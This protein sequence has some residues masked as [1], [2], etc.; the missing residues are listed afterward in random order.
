MVRG[1][2]L[3]YRNAAHN[4]E[5]LAALNRLNSNMF[6]I[7]SIEANPEIVSSLIPGVLQRNAKSWL[8]LYE[9]D[10]QQDLLILPFP[11]SSD[12]NN[13]P[14]LRDLEELF[15]YIDRYSDNWHYITYHLDRHWRRRRFNRQYQFIHI[16]VSLGSLLDR[17]QV[18]R[19]RRER[20][21]IQSTLRGT[22]QSIQQQRNQVLSRALKTSG[23]QRAILLDQLDNVFVVENDKILNHLFASKGKSVEVV[24]QIVKDF[25]DIMDPETRK[26]LITS[27]TVAQSAHI[28]S[29]DNFDYSAPGC[30]L[31]KAVERELNL[32]LVLYLRQVKGVV[33]SDDPWKG[34]K[35]PWERVDV[36]TGN[37]YRDKV[38]LNQRERRGSNKLR[39]IE[40][41]PTMYMLK[42]GYSNGV[43]RVL[44]G[45]SPNN[46]MLWY[47]FLGPRHEGS[48]RI[49]TLPW[50]LE[51]ILFLR[52]G[53]AHISAMSRK[54][55]EELR[56]FVLPS[57]N[58][59]KT[60]LV[61]ILQL[62]R[63]IQRAYLTKAWSPFSR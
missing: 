47:Y 14:I 42:W 21:E 53:H 52:N 30:G 5:T 34:I 51:K 2:F 28:Y 57:D 50:W 7:W 37:S 60:C 48:L 19:Q 56:N 45:L 15:H 36:V 32:S 23:R 3:Y 24:P 16:D 33:T 63:Q 35:G 44:R 38:N 31:W 12:N 11:P 20:Q 61:K 39:G 9:P 22:S 17:P 49:N 26:F 1:V 27:E 58:I 10:R 59:P 62:K 43:E 18:P 4:E 13:F 54:D 46:T 29:S 8:I 6:E 41:G 40:L 55:F 25:A